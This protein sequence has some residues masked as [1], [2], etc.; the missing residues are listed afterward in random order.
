MLF[1]ALLLVGNGS[2]ES[3]PRT[4]A[5]DI[6]RQQPVWLSQ[7]EAG[8]PIEYRTQHKGPPSNVYK[9]LADAYEKGGHGQKR[10][11]PIGKA[12]QLW[13]GPGQ[14]DGLD[15]NR[16]KRHKKE[17][18][19]RWQCPT[20]LFGVASLIKEVTER[21]RDLLEIEEPL[22]ELPKSWEVDG[23]RVAPVARAHAR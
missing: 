10:L 22:E 2:T 23:E 14:Q 13:R 16:L 5:S 11:I 1:M 21:L 9:P 18:N 19:G 3:E 8:L 20:T 4:W 15:W 7:G 6:V 12:M 17:L